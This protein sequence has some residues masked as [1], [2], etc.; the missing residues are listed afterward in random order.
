MIL[1]RLLF[2]NYFH[3]IIFAYSNKT[4]RQCGMSYALFVDILGESPGV[5]L[6]LC[7]SPDNSITQVAFPAKLVYSGFLNFSLP[8]CLS[9]SQSYQG[10]TDMPQPSISSWI[11]TLLC[12]HYD[13]TCSI[14]QMGWGWGNP[15]NP[16]RNN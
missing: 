13:E 8:K 12:H 11:A 15:G 3:V 7:L 14:I 4:G 1:L 16:C 5:R 10:E 9:E 2:L 6:S